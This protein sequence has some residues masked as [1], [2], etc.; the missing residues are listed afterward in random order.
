M[1]KRRN[2]LVAHARLKYTL[3]G[4]HRH[5]LEKKVP[6]QWR[7]GYQIYGQIVA[8]LV[9]NGIDSF[10]VYIPFVPMKMFYMQKLCTKKGNKWSIVYNIMAEHVYV[11][12]CARAPVRRINRERISN[13][14]KCKIDPKKRE[15]KIQFRKKLSS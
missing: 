6:R 14:R 12:E 11:F 13:I 1:Q 5:R 7:F 4:W 8:T 9:K 15:K 2:I 10:C 3:I